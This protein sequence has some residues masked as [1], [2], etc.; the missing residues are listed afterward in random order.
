MNA[1]WLE[2]TEVDVP[3]ELAWLSGRELEQLHG[4]RFAKRR[5]DW[6]LGRW[7]A[8]NAVAAC[9][10]LS[11]G[12]VNLAEIEVRPAP[13]GAPEAFFA[14]KPAPVTISVSHRA[15][16]GACAVTLSSGALGCDLEMIE[17]VSDAFVSDYF[18]LEEQEWVAQTPEE[19]RPLLL[20]LVW[21][22]KESTLKVLHAGLRLDTRCVVVTRPDALGRLQDREGNQQEEWA[23]N[24][25]FA[26]ER[27]DAA[28]GWHPLR[29]R[30]LHGQ[31]FHGWWQQISN[32]LRT[33]VAAPPPLP[34]LLLNIPRTS[35][36]SAS[37]AHSDQPQAP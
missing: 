19:H 6:L 34:P 4:M 7:T 15:G 32:R 24:P 31:T 9:L 11:A 13:S 26:T 5:A 28:N 1:Y 22:A 30:H 36:E 29:V 27:L 8:K 16:M 20:T 21:S 10:R 23:Q 17:P 18:A 2:Q 14:N 12:L 3:G 37:V 25:D 35:T 33:L